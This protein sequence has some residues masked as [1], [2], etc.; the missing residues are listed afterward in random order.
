MKDL[1][2]TRRA[3]LRAYMERYDI[4]QTELARRLEVGR[5]YVSLLLTTNKHFGEKAARS[6]ES[7]L[8]LQTGYL[9]G[10]TE[11]NTPVETWDKP[12]DLAPDVYALVPRL[13]IGLSAGSGVVIVDET[14]LPPLA[15]RRDWLIKKNV[16]NKSNLRIVSVKGDSMAP[17]L[18]NGD[19]DDDRPR[20]EGH[21]GRL[22]VRPALR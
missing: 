19:I 16:T 9:D 3:L 5:A 21:R 15:F 7:K 6:I 18:E 14:E 11:K 20:P 8:G 22:R 12:E 2:E 17:Y 10:L 4:N 13:S 1:A